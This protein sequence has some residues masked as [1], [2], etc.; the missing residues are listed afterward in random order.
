MYKNNCNI[1]IFYRYLTTYLI[2][3]KL[4]C[5]VSYLYSSTN[6]DGSLFR[7]GKRHQ[8]TCDRFER[9]RYTRPR[10]AR[11]ARDNI[12]GLRNPGGVY[13]GRDRDRPI[14]AH[15]GRLGAYALCRRRPAQFTAVTIRFASF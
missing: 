6:P 12:R 14:P 15:R 9:R 8:S 10:G 7:K 11:A 2:Q 3:L 4:S 1:I 13:S 5:I